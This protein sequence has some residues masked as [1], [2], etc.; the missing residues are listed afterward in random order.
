MLLNKR[1]ILTERK[2]RDLISNHLLFVSVAPIPH[3]ILIDY[4]IPPSPVALCL[5]KS[6]RSSRDAFPSNLRIITRFSKL[7][8]LQSTAE[9]ISGK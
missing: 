5:M 1:N 6:P 7:L 4:Y 2:F 3:H 8:P 9:M